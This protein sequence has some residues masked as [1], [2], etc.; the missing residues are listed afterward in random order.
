MIFELAHTPYVAGYAD[1]V[2]PLEDAKA[3]LRVTSD[4][5]DDLIKALVLASIEFVEKY[6]GLRLVETADLTWRAESLPLRSCDR[7]K[8][9]VYPVSS[10]ESVTWLDSA[11]EA[12]TGT[13]SDFRI[14]PHGTLLPAVGK[15]WPSGVGGGVE[16]SFTAG[17]PDGE[18]PSG[19]ISAVKLFLGHLYMNREAVVSTG[20]SGEVPL[21][22]RTLCAPYRMPRI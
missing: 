21:G 17:F 19:L 3:H 14:G 11:G 9:G 12:V 6:C 1:G 7:V 5:E 10:I 4:S 16:I 22:V 8:L 13:L 2:L 20:A 18:V 15:S